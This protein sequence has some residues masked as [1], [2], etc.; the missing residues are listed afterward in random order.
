MEKF[1]NLLEQLQKLKIEQNS[2]DW[3]ENIPEDVWEEHFNGNFK[4]VKTGLNVDTHRWYETSISVIEIYG[5]FIGIEHI[6]NLFSESSSCSDCGVEIEFYEMEQVLQPT[7]KIKE[8][9]QQ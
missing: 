1:K 3:A 4:E 8:T 9:T 6:T 2:I 7:F 5:G